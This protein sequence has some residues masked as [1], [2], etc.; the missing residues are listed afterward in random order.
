MHR[1]P[2]WARGASRRAPSSVCILVGRQEEERRRDG[3]KNKEEGG[4]AHGGASIVAFHDTKK[5]DGDEWV[6]LVED[7]KLTD[8]ICRLGPVR[9]D[10]PWHVICDGE[11]F[12]HTPE[13]RKA[14]TD[15]KVK[16]WTVPPRSPDLNPVENFWSWLRAELHE[17][18]FA[19]LAAKRPVLCKTEYK[20]RIRSIIQS[21]KAR[22]VA[23]SIVKGFKKVCRE[24]SKR[25]GAASSR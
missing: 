20:S 5:L 22:R 12:L 25:K 13:S 11:S 1:I 23:R 3:I 2:H 7:G 24:V 10:G 21:P 9:H 17:R 4:I 14:L 8:A 18:D 15:C 16:L 6:D 19:D